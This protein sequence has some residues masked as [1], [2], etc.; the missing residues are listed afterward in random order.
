MSIAQPTDA[1]LRELFGIDEPRKARCPFFPDP[2]LLS[3][4]HIE[5]LLV[6]Q[7]GNPSDPGRR[8]WVMEEIKATAES[9]LSDVALQSSNTPTASRDQL[10]R[11]QS[12]ARELRAALAWDGESFETIPYDPAHTWLRQ[13]AEHYRGR[14]KLPQGVSPYDVPWNYWESWKLPSSIAGVRLLELWAQDAR[15]L[16]KEKSDP[17]RRGPASRHTLRVTVHRLCLCW[18]HAYGA[19]P[20]A[21]IKVVD[22][23]A[24]ENRD[25]YLPDGPFTRFAVEFFENMRQCASEKQMSD[26]PPL[27]RLLNPSRHTIRKY[28]QLFKHRLKG[29]AGTPK[30]R[31]RG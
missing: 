4:T 6:T 13:A 9:F 15:D 24:I 27:E 8:R 14:V 30:R 12:A 19:P 16:V 28:I 31:R 10:K 11:I 18:M 23:L 1:E 5:S 20:G 2:I 7:L 17:V 29:K 26:Y 3:D 21:G 22:Q 25:R